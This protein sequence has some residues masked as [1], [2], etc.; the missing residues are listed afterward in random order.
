MM[1]DL[2][3][4]KLRLRKRSRGVETEGVDL[5]T[6]YIDR[7]TKEQGNPDFIK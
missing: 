6:L 2:S 3:H 5:G 4:L 7:K 1:Q